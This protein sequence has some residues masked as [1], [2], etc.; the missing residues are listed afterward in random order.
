MNENDFEV[1]SG[2][3][4]CL[5]ICSADGLI[6]QEEE[7]SLCRE[8]NEAFGINKSTFED[9]VDRFFE[10]KSEIEFY[11]NSVSGDELKVKFLDI[12]R[13]S[14]AVDGFDITE[15]IAWKKC[16]EHWGLKDVS[17]S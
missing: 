10:D 11:L 17:E 15:N 12:A 6:S 8:F 2:L 16:K 7:E 3:L 9:I 14:A 1:E 13:K 4:V 5:A